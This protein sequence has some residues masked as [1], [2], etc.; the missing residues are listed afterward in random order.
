MNIEIIK[1]YKSMS[2]SMQNLFTNGFVK[3]NSMQ[4]VKPV[5]K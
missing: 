4:S 3:K 2:D 1:K 5:L